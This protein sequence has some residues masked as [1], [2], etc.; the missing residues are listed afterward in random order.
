M[1][2]GRGRLVVSQNL[3]QQEHKAKRAWTRSE[4]NRRVLLTIQ[5]NLSTTATSGTEESGRCRE[6]ETR[7]TVCTVRQK[8]N[9]CCRDVV[10]NGGSTVY[11]NRKLVS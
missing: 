9:G 11:V 5:L 2:L 10:V 3:I 7:V 1:F 4:D 6:V 8:K